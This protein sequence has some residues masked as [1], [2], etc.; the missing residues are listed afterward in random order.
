MNR[1]VQIE[2]SYNLQNR[3]SQHTGVFMI[4]TEAQFGYFE[5]FWP[6][7]KLYII[8]RKHQSITLLRY[9]SKK[10]KERERIIIN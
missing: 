4:N 7:R 6:H 3:R 10:N 8:S 2:C 5:V 1:C 9:K